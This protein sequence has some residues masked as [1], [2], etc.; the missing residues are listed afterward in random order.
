VLTQALHEIVAAEMQLS[1][2]QSTAD[3]IATGNQKSTRAQAKLIDLIAASDT[4]R[5][6]EL[7]RRH[8]HAVGEVLV[9]TVGPAYVIDIV[10]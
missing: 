9:R 8:M 2:Q 6:V 7:W 4:T 1:R 3:E 5:A 10:E